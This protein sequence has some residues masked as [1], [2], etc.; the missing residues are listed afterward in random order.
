MS[1]PSNTARTNHKSQMRTDLFAKYLSKLNC[2]NC[3]QYGYHYGGSI[4]D[5]LMG[6]KPSNYDI[7]LC[8]EACVSKYMHEI[9]H[10][11]NVFVS[12]DS[13]NGC[14]L[15]KIISKIYPDII[16]YLNITYNTPYTD[17]YF[18]IDVN[19][20][21]VLLH[22]YSTGNKD[23]VDITL[24][25]LCIVNTKCDIADIM[26]NI[27]A[28]QFI[29]LD[30]S[31]KPEMCHQDTVCIN[32]FSSRGVTLVKRINKMINRG[33]R[34]INESCSNETCVMASMA[35][36]KI[37]AVMRMLYRTSTKKQYAKIYL[38]R[39]RFARPKFASITSG[40]LMFQF[41]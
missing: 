36:R 12:L 16:F 14:R 1:S 22:N 6:I 15:T 30:R 7:D 18:D 5:L 17:L 40:L 41:L 23:Y 24:G 29:V 34:C 27:K 20:L 3:W 37:M 9:D 32:R 33:W 38:T 10:D 39:R 8:S 2:N 4:R 21:I 25:N 35:I 28:K 11:Y 13:Y 31:G 19:M 26:F